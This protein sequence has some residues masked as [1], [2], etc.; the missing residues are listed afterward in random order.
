[1]SA[2]RLIAAMAGW[3]VVV[4]TA[5]MARGQSPL[6][7]SGA[8]NGDNARARTMAFL[9]TVSDDQFAVAFR[10]PENISDEKERVLALVNYFNW[11][12][13]RHPDWEIKK[14]VSYRIE[15]LVS[16]NCTNTLGNIRNHQT[17]P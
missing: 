15:L 1:M 12:Y 16:H 14:I 2:L 11:A 5:E 6:P 7:Q 8:S 9:A 3:L 13:A 17:Y 10:C 4:G